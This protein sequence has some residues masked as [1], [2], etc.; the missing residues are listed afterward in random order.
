[1][2]KTASDV[3]VER[4]IDWG[5]DT[6]FGIPGDGINGIMEAL[7]TH[8]QQI[9]FIQVR[10]EEA[11][12]FAAC[13]FA[14]FTGKLGV[15][16]ATSGPGAIHLLNG[17]YD[18]KMDGA[19]VLALT[20]QQY[21][22]LLGSHYQQEVNLLALYEDVAA[23]NQQVQ[24]PTQ[25]YNLVDTA[26]RTAFSQRTVAHITFPIDL[27]VAEGKV[28]FVA[29]HG[30]PARTP[31]QVAPF[32]PEFYSQNGGPGRAGEMYKGL[33]P[34]PTDEVVK[35]AAEVLNAGKRVALIVGHGALHAGPEVLQVADLLGA[36]IVKSL[37]GKGVVEDDNPFTTGGLGLLG[38]G[39]SQD[40]MEQC[41]TLFMIG[42]SFPYARYLPKPGQARGVQLDIDHT[43]IGLRY[44]V[45]VGLVGDAKPTLQTLI[46]YLKRKAD[47]S[48]LEKQQKAMKGWNEFMHKEG[49]RPD[50]PMKPQVVAHALNELAAPDAII[51]GDSGTNTTWIAR[52]FSIRQNQMFSCSGNLATMAPGLPYAIGAQVAYPGRQ[53]IAFVGDGAFTMLMG[54]MITAV[55]YQLP[56]KVIIIKNDVLG[57]IK[58]EQIVFLGNPEYGV[59]LQPADFAAWARAAGGEGYRVADPA[60]VKEVMR[61]FLAS[62][63]PAVLEALVD[64][65]E[66]PMP[67]KVKPE[68]A[69]KFA[70]ALVKGQPQGPRI[71]ITAF[72]DKVSE[73]V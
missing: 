55:K 41:D 10:H 65:N 27:Q 29:H 17:L 47:R 73:Y 9:R 31:G 46:P 37:L 12:A 61:E 24:S 25:V 8:Q 43:R 52:N 35:Q 18:A 5:V 68:Q 45:E 71:A 63:K 59:E 2:A 67:G 7:R 1:M 4:L 64:P 44:P 30:G 26:C 28:E 57:Q 14:K 56:I 32:P 34:A 53:V 39:P 13:A 51:T 58:W 23:F 69:V 48:F 70:K 49:E 40:V 20:G 38:T 11:A 22:D 66:P 62:P 60:N 16:L 50:I 54:E 21:S 36:P 19:P 3:M 15:C 42:T 33:H 6:V 72:R